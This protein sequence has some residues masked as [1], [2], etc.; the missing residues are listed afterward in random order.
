MWPVFSMET[1]QCYVHFW[2][3]SISW[4]L[5]ALASLDFKLSVSQSVSNWY[6]LQLAHL[7]VFQIY[8]NWLGVEAF[9]WLNLR[10][11]A[12][13]NGF[14]A[15]LCNGVRESGWFDWLLIRQTVMA[16]MHYVQNHK[17]GNLVQSAQCFC[18]SKWLCLG[19]NQ[20][21]CVQD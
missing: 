16:Q 1:M 6:F 19:G 5:D 13:K 9:L 2:C 20:L 15:I 17:R 8:F 14:S 11:S 18:A 4:F 7:R 3:A 10:S 21:L 12:M